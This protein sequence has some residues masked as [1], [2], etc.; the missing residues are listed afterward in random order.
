[1]TT[2]ATEHETPAFTVHRAEDAADGKILEIHGGWAPPTTAAGW[3]RNATAELLRNRG[4]TFDPGRDLMQAIP[5]MDATWLASGLDAEG[6][7]VHV[8]VNLA[9]QAA[10]VVDTGELDRLDREDVGVHLMA[11]MLMSDH[12][13]AGYYRSSYIVAAMVFVLGLAA[14]WAAIFLI[15]HLTGA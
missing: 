4:I 15:D 10:T 2:A 12:S 8:A 5:G 1:M 11:E 6:N 13:N 3:V 14:T 7:R 9:L